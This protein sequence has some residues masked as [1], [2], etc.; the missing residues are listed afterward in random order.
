MGVKRKELSMDSSLVRCA[1]TLHFATGFWIGPASLFLSDRPQRDSI[2]RRAWQVGSIYTFMRGIKNLVSAQFK[3][4]DQIK[5]RGINKLTSE[6]PHRIRISVTPAT[7]A[8]V[9]NAAMA[10]IDGRPGRTQIREHG[11]SAAHIHVLIPNSDA[12]KRS[13][14]AKLECG[15]ISRR[16]KRPT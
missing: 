8:T 14:A 9:R 11:F 5:I 16:R 1:E 2:T 7:V 13:F 15:A 3:F 10:K 4:A 6:L 12:G